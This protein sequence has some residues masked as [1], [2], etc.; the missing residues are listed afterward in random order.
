[1]SSM[2][3]VEFTELTGKMIAA[4]EEIDVSAKNAD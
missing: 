4:V 3:N 1:V 2:E